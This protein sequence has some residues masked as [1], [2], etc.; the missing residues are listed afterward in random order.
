VRSPEPEKLDL[1][2]VCLMVTEHPLYLGSTEG[3]AVFDFLDFLATV[4]NEA[5][6]E[7]VEH[8]TT[9]RDV[10][11]RVAGSDAKPLR[12]Q[13]ALSGD[14]ARAWTGFGKTCRREIWGRG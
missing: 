7:S 11:R 5:D 4:S 9:L 10:T 2:E 8:L 12:R 14:W 13:I 3:L 6:D 1:R